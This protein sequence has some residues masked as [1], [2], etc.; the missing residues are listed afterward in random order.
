[1]RTIFV[2]LE[3]RVATWRSGWPVAELKRR[4]HDV[5][6]LASAAGYDDSR[7]VQD[8][9]EVTYVL[10][11]INRAYRDGNR[12]TT[13]LDVAKMFRPAGRLIL[14]VDDD[15]TEMLSVQADPNEPLAQAVHAQTADLYALPDRIIASTPRLVDIFSR[16]NSDVVLAENVMPEWVLDM[17]QPPKLEVICWMGEMYVHGID[18]NLLEPYAPDLP[19]LRLIGSGGYARNMLEKWGARKVGSS[20]PIL[21]ARKLYAEMGRAVGAIIPL[22][23]TGFNRGKSWSKPMEFLAR[24]VPTVASAH[25]EYE[26]LHSLTGAVPTFANPAGLVAAA[27]DLWDNRRDGSDLPD[28]LRDAGLTMER[29][30]GDAWEKALI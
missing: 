11:V 22:A 23:D 27:V 14:S 29:S 24:G 20:P 4:G 17:P 6:L 21:E 15:W 1:M 3:E 25:A 30:G 28:R 9:E 10:H 2:C 26:R 16:F 18:W 13:L 7:P 12:I 19:P 8:G 5:D